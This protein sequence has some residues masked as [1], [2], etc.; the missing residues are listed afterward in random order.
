MRITLLGPASILV[1][2]HGRTVLIDPVFT[3]P[4]GEGAATSCPGRRV[5]RDRF[6]RIDLL[7]VS[8]ARPHHFDVSTLAA[9]ARDCVVVC[10]RNALVARALEKLGFRDVRPCS[11][12]SILRF[13]KFELW[14]TSSMRDELELGVALKDRTGTFW[15]QLDTVPSVEMIDLVR[16]TFG[17]IDLLLATYTTSNMMYLGTARAG[18]P[19]TSHRAS[20]AC[21][22][23]VSP[24]L[25]V[26]ASAGLKTERPA[27][28]RSPTSSARRR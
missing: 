9:L 20:I 15:A 21:A 5:H 23:R 12:N 26:P 8:S 2:L 16:T 18:F 24:R 27:P 7:V 14:A 11:A 4:F 3:D 25:A 6:P 19:A 1:E 28:C 17:R 22:R 13:G 10:S